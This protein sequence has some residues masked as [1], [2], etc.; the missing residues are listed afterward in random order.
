MKITVIGLDLAK[1]VF[2]VCMLNEH[3]KIKKNAKVTPLQAAELLANTP[4]T[5]VA[6]EACGSAHY[7]GRLAQQHGHE[8]RL[9]PPQHV[10]AFRRVHKSDGH[11]ALAIVEAAQRPNL[12]PVPVKS[13]EQQELAMLVQ[14]RDQLVVERTAKSNQIRGFAREFGLNFPRGTDK[15]LAAIAELSVE[16]AQYSTRTCMVLAELALDLTRLRE[17]IEKVDHELAE[18]AARYPA[19]ARLQAI[20]GIGP[21]IA[22]A[23][24][25]KVGDG[26]QFANGRQMAAWVGLVPRQN[27]TGGKV[28]LGHI[29]KAGDRQLRRQLI[30]GARTVM[31]WLDKQNALLRNW[32]AGIIDR[33][34]KKRAIVAYA[35]KLTRLAY[36]ALTSEEAFDIKRAFGTSAS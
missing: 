33:R 26:K 24:I 27:G 9:L 3:G 16:H 6:M 2:Q 18:V 13:V 22:A 28:Q 10:K 8:V 32:A 4:P 14:L 31:R 12:H 20:P 36:R 17:R 29:T 21:V 19:Y 25:A 1:N 15:L 7:W 23:L 11:D 5:L 34:G 35:N 30:H